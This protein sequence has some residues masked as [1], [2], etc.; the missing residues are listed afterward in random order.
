ML[1]SCVPSNENSDSI[2]GR[3]FLHSLNRQIV[4]Q[5]GVRLLLL[6]GINNNSSMTDI[7]CMSCNICT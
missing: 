6:L 5:A 3:K 7:S 2:E 4:S 1:G